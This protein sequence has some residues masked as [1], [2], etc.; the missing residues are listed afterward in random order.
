MVQTGDGHAGF[1]RLREQ[2]FQ[3]KGAGLQASN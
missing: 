3:K 2:L 1:N